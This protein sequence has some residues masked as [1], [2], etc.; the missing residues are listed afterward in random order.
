MAGKPLGG[1]QSGY[2]NSNQPYNGGQAYNANPAPPYSPP[3]ENQQTGNTFNS[4]EGYY[5]QQNN[6]YGGYGG[7]NNGIELQPPQS[8]YAPPRGVNGEPLY[9]APQGPPP[10]GKADGIIR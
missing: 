2:Y 4:N 3:M 1:Q 8:V 6:G 7:Q 9:E 10:P 5:G